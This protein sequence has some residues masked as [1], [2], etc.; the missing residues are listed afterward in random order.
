M[1]VASQT[2]APPEAED[3]TLDVGGLTWSAGPVGAAPTGDE[4]T[5]DVRA[6]TRP[7]PL[8]DEVTTD[9]RALGPQ[10]GLEGPRAA[11]RSR[12]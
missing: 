1:D 2:G 12:R 3:V 8:D 4:R 10:R 11:D 9:V 7:A 6:L 5:L